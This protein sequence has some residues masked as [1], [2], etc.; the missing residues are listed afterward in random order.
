MDLCGP[1]GGA[2]PENLEHMI[3]DLEV[4]A[5]REIP[6]QIVDRAG[7]E[8]HRLATVFAKQM[9]SVSGRTPDIDGVAVRLH[10]PGE[11]VDG[12][13]DLKRPVYRRPA[14]ARS[15]RSLAQLRHELF[16]GKWPGVAKDSVDDGRT[17]SGQAVAVF[18]E[19]ALDFGAGKGCWFSMVRMS[20]VINHVL[21]ILRYGDFVSLL[22]CRDGDAVTSVTEIGARKPMRTLAHR[23]GI[24]VH[25]WTPDD[26]RVCRA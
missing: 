19:D 5:F 3:V 10:D 11:D 1:A 17:R 22:R 9:V 16:G 8:G 20:T 14:N 4:G 7:R 13:E 24:L 23:N 6:D 18:A 25:T 21:I 15:F 26:D 2:N 12:G